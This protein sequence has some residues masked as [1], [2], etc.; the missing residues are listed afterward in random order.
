MPQQFVSVMDAAA[1]LATTSL[2]WRLIE[3]QIV[4]LPRPQKAKERKT[5]NGLVVIDEGYGYDCGWDDD[6]T[7]EDEKETAASPCSNA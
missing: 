3:M 2:R 4:L 1:V 5:R 7:D 6:D